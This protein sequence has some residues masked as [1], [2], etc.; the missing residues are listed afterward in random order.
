MTKYR[1][2]I[3]LRTN[4]FVEN[5]LRGISELNG[6][7]DSTAKIIPLATDYI[8][9]VDTNNAFQDSVTTVNLPFMSP[10]GQVPETMTPYQAGDRTTEVFKKLPICIYSFADKGHV[11][12]PWMRCGQITYVFYHDDVSLLIEISNFVVDLCKREDWAASDINYFYRND[13]T[14]PFDFKCIS[15]LSG[16]GP[17]PV[18]DEGGRYSYMIIIYC[19][20]TYEGL[21]RL[22]N[23][24]LGNQKDLGM[25]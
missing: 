23:Y 24:S 5:R 9:D 14:N 20:A 25:I 11:D 8:S 22:N 10:A 19:D 16:A 15:L 21:N 17:M 4:K 18:D 13:A 1:E 6:V 12:E 3:L 2:S 7:S